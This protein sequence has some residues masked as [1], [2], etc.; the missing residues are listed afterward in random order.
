MTA[1]LSVDHRLMDGVAA[2]CFLEALD[3]SLRECPIVG[4]CRFAWQKRPRCDE[5]AQLAR[6]P[7]EEG[8]DVG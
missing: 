1:T 8:T 7:I 3:G 2:A 6:I 5:F 4:D